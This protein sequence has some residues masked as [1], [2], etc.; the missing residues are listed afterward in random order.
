M[1]CDFQVQGN[2]TKPYWTKIS[3]F[4]QQVAN[5]PPFGLCCLVLHGTNGIALGAIGQL[6]RGEL[7]GRAPQGV[8]LGVG[9]QVKAGEL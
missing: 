6:E 9:T 4:G 7:V 2:A 5:F 3:G 8:Q 1:I